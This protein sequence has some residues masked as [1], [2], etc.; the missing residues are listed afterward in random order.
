[1]FPQCLVP[2]AMNTGLLAAVTALPA[3]AG[4]LPIDGVYGTPEA[5]QKF[6]IGGLEAVASGSDSGEDPY[7]VVTPTQMMG[8]EVECSF[9]DNTLGSTSITCADG[10]EF[11]L[12]PLHIS[13]KGEALIWNQPHFKAELHPCPVDEQG[14]M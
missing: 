12:E 13:L 8:F 9:N 6:A 10:G 7:M 5:C 2:R 1:M 4:E 14:I 3:L 11:W